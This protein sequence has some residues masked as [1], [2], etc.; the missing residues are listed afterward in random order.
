MKRLKKYILLVLM[1]VPL[2]GALGQTEV[3][4]KATLDSTR[5]FIGGQIDLKL[6]VS[7]PYGLTLKFPTFK[8]TIVKSVEVVE[9][10]KIDTLSRANGRIEMVQKVRITSFDSGLHYIPPMQV[11]VWSKTAKSIASSNE[12]G[13]NVVN[14]FSDVDPKKGVYDIKTVINTPF[15][16]SELLAY[17]WVLVLLIL[18]GVGGFYLVKYLKSRNAS[19]AT[20]F[21]PEAPKIPPY[22][23]ALQ[24]LE[25]IREEKIWQ[26]GQ[27]KQF[28][29]QLTE[30][31]RTYIE[32]QFGVAALESTTDELISMMKR[33]KTVDDRLLK[34]LKDIL[35]QADLV[36]FAKYIPLSEENDTSLSQSLRFVQ[37]TKPVEVESAKEDEK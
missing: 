24:E 21:K 2:I 16:F 25:R 23:V 29:T 14:P 22:V 7:Q 15:L 4:V 11:E 35:E 28:Y 3:N 27:E 9:V 8:D 5:I 32:E 26:K 31:L 6:E 19:L 17:W 10:G 20:I 34:L 36:K 12:N 1:L 18:I 37:E 13:L 30:V 33:S